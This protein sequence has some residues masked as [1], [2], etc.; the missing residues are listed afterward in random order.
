MRGLNTTY[1][2]SRL[3]VQK[4]EVEERVEQHAAHTE[5]EVTR[6]LTVYYL[7]KWQSYVSRKLLAV[8][9]DEEGPRVPL[10]ECAETW[11]GRAA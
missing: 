2:C 10:Q 8:H 7:R 3:L 4:C 6:H 9:G 1:R 5:R 11:R